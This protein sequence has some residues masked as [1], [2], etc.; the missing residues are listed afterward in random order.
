MIDAV[1][2]G[3]LRILG[4]DAVRAL[5]ETRVYAGVLEQSVTLPA[6]VVQRVSESST[7]HLRGGSNL[8]ATRLQVTSVAATRAAAVALDL[9]IYGD[10]AGGGLAFWH[11]G[12]GSPAV[13]VRLVEPAGT[14]EEYHAAELKQFRVARD[15]VMH[16]R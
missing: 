11:G 5:V 8:W 14:T 2:T 12:L 13:E 4:I 3:R 7:G 6:A 16:H 1:A 9:A 10:N 15:Y